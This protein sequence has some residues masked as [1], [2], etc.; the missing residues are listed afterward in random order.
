MDNDIV[1]R[2]RLHATFVLPNHTDETSSQSVMQEA[3]DE[4]ERLRD[5]LADTRSALLRVEMQQIRSARRW[6]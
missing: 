3:A 1:T 2:L 6:R 4:I 5:E